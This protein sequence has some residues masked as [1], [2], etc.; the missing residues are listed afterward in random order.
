MRKQI[1]KQEAERPAG[2]DFQVTHRDSEGMVSHSNPY[3]MH[4]L[5]AGGNDRITVMERPKSSGNCWDA[6]N[7]PA[8]R[9]VLEEGKLVHKP[10][11]AH[12]AWS[13]PETKD[14]KLARETMKM[15]SENE[16]L[17]KELEALKAE[18]EVKPAVGKAQTQ[19]KNPKES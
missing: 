3:T 1:E 18:S 17:R 7:N 12:I 8:G 5:G 9:I 16:A 11:E 10:K 15:R 19:N 2:F 14:Q 13:A 4:V 6:Q